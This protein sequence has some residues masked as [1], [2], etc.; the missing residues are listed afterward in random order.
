MLLGYNILY[1]IKCEACHFGLSAVVGWLGYWSTLTILSRTGLQ[2]IL[3]ARRTFLLLLLVALSYAV[4][5]HIVEDYT[6]NWF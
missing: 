5:A 3:T 1:I 2:A 6:I 4:L